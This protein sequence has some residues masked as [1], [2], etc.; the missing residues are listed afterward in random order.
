MS[1]QRLASELMLGLVCVISLRS[2]EYV[3]A[4]QLAP[5]LQCVPR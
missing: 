5:L 4:C 1:P 2:S 3:T